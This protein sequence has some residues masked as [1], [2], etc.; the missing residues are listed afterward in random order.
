MEMQ[1]IYK[2]VYSHWKD[3]NNHL[4]I[5]GDL[6][7]HLNNDSSDKIVVRRHDNYFMDIRKESIIS[8]EQVKPRP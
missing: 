5:H 6:P 2:V 4:T 7:D 8:V 1:R 3:A